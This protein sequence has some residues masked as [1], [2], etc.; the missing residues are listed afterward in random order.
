M[1]AT[2]TKNYPLTKDEAK[3]VHDCVQSILKFI[4]NDTEKV[5]IAQSVLTKMEEYFEESYY[6]PFG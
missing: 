4:E 3:F 1:Y 2:Y 6:P 5:R